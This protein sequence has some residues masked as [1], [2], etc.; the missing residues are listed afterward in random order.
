MTEHGGDPNQPGARPG[1]TPPTGAHRSGGT[2]GGSDAPTG[3]QQV[4]GGQWYAAPG[5]PQG[6]PQYGQP[7]PWNQQLPHGQPPHG[8]PEYG[9]PQQYGQPQQWGQQ[10]PQ[11]WGQP[12]QQQ[13][14]QPPGQPQPWG[15]PQGAPQQ[16]SPSGTAQFAVPGGPPPGDTPARKR[17]AP[18]LITAAAVVVLLVAGGLVWF[19]ADR[20]TSTASG[21]ASPQE[22]VVSLVSALNDSDPVGAASTLDPAEA[23]LYQDFS[24]DLLSELERLEII[25]P[26]VDP[27]AVTGSRITMSDITY[28]SVTETMPG[29]LAFVQLTGGTITI[30]SDPSSV[31]YTDKI[32]DAL[33][34]TM[35][36]LT[37]QEPVTQTVQVAEITQQLGQPLRVGV[38]NR[39]GEWYAS[40][41]Y[42]LAGLATQA[43]RLPDPTAADI[44]P[45]RGAG[46]E[47][48][49]VDALLIALEKGDWEGAISILP[50]DE[51]GVLHDYGRLI[52][53]EA[54][55]AGAEE[56][57]DEL[58]G[59]A[60][61]NTEWDVVDVTGG[62]KVTL[63]S[64][65]ISRAGDTL[66]LRR[67]VEAETLQI[68]GIPGQPTITLDDASIDTFIAELAEG[69]ELPAQLQDLIKREFKQLLGIGF[70]TV[71]VDGEWYVSPLRSGGDVLLQLMRGMEPADIDFFLEMLQGN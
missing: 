12:P 62:R 64:A 49:A 30:T 47:T 16:F 43:A 33:N 68:S 44:I 14:G 39:D 40:M 36:G 6:Q 3:P 34:A 58:E 2:P 63:V 46:S 18:L 56:D 45:A 15:H 69:E 8:Q 37:T 54:Q 1:P 10:Q 48:E 35:G 57:L 66:S 51:M 65:D 67:D 32:N 13:W 24:D 71:E 60:I 50:P 25:K 20:E 61:T 41:F 7:Q 19:L 42:T 21:Q 5:Q 26:D 9:P 17:S 38:V 28:G 52:L 31:P 22:A 53:R 11:Q 23:A 59:F 29:H 27:N 55:R 70:V 4:V